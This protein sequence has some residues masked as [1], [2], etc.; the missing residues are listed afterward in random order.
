MLQETAFRAAL[1]Q[2]GIAPA[3][4]ALL[5]AMWQRNAAVLARPRRGC[6]DHRWS[7]K[8][9]RL[10]ALNG[11]NTASVVAFFLDRDPTIHAWWQ[12]P[13]E[14]QWKT[15]GP[16]GKATGTKRHE[17]QF[18]VLR[19]DGFV[20]LDFAKDSELITRMEAGQD[21]EL[22]PSDQS[23]RWRAAE[24]E[25]AALGM[26]YEV[27]SISSVPFI[28]HQ[29]LRD[30]D[31]YQDGLYQLTED[32]RDRLLAVF[33]HEGML[34]IR[35]CVDAHDIS[36]DTI[37]RALIEGLIVADLVHTHLAN[38]DCLVFRDPALLNGWLAAQV[39]EPALPLP[40]EEEIDEKDAIRYHG[41]TYVVRLVDGDEVFL[42]GIGDDMQIA[43]LEQLKLL[44]AHARRAQ[45]SGLEPRVRM[46]YVNLSDAER[47]L[48]LARLNLIEGKPQTLIQRPSDRTLQRWR[49]IAHAESTRIRKLI[50][51]GRNRRPGNQSERFTRRHEVFVRWCVRKYY[52]RNPK[53]SKFSAYVAYTKSLPCQEITLPM[54]EMTFNHRVDLYSKRLDKF[55]KRSAYQRSNL[56]GVSQFNNSPHGVLPHQ[57]VHVDHTP[58]DVE[59]VNKDGSNL[60]RAW[61]TL[62]WDASM[63][64][65]RAMVLTFR[66]PNT[67]TILLGIRDYAKR[68]QCLPKLIV[69]DG[70]AEL[71]TANVR[72]LEVAYGIEIRT[73]KGSEGRSGSPIENRF[74]TREKEGDA[75]MHGNTSHL[76]A[77]REYTGRVSPKDD[78]EWT[79][80]ALYK[81]YDLYFFEYLGKVYVDPSW[82]KTPDMHEKEVRRYCGEKDFI[83]V[84]Y[85]FSLVILTSPILAPQQHVVQKQGVQANY[86]YYTNSA[87]R[88]QKPGGKVSVR[89]EPH[90]ANIVYVRVGEKWTIAVAR[91]LRLFEGFTLYQAAIAMQQWRRQNRS[92]WRQSKRSN[93]AFEIRHAMLHA[94]NFDPRLLAL[95]QEEEA[96]LRD[97]TGMDVSLDETGQH[98][99]LGRQKPKEAARG[100][101][102]HVASP[103]PP[104]GPLTEPMESSTSIAPLPAAV[105]ET[106]AYVETGEPV[107]S[108]NGSSP[109]VSES[110]R[111]ESGASAPRRRRPPRV[112]GKDA[113]KKTGFV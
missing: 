66:K 91:D 45:A 11:R 32:G 9:G 53:S 23:W 10:V 60:K 35:E 81:A 7:S 82:G 64:R 58:V 42:Q 105:L 95:Q 20:V 100:C 14:Y 3:G 92:L 89:G 6:V 74:G 56:P 50:A 46:D 76:K 107:D 48:G 99:C 63:K 1:V 15:V 102:E 103:P 104:G 67:D 113:W 108:A 2:Y 52:D 110:G 65:A 75:Q 69:V 30:L 94:K 39:P 101:A 49:R 25:Y 62:F 47:E 18:V 34:K 17:P 72:E 29:N 98:L 78:A 55:G 57:V 87:I 19:D 88:R 26:R 59:L 71:K 8:M 31:R 40:F 79:L 51:L 16:T 37:R 28:L 4:T 27:H 77:A 90:C 43:S 86:A 5:R 38:P 73:R 13:F 33:A 83:A 109:E 61:F 12:Q 21:Y 68:W 36:A 112:L 24:R 44:K 84:D 54:S 80:P 85:D 93:R 106:P 97:E 41:K 96:V 111:E 70:A 22:M